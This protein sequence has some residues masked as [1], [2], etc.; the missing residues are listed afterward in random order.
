MRTIIPLRVPRLVF[1][2]GVAA[3]LVF[4][5]GS[6]MAA[7]AKDTGQQ[8]YCGFHFYLESC[9]QCCGKFQASW[10]GV[11]CWCGPDTKV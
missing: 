8:F 6:A 11:E 3:A 5:A 1:G 9:E 7:P 4:G 10:E 2:A